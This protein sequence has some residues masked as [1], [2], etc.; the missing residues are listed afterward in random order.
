MYMPPIPPGTMITHD[1]EDTDLAWQLYSDPD[2]RDRL[3]RKMLEELE[4]AEVKYQVG[5]DGQNKKI[6]IVLDL[7]DVLGTIEIAFDM[8]VHDEANRTEEDDW[9]IIDLGD[10]DDLDDSDDL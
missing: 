7:S 2:M 1:I 4:L 5:I 3:R 9:I 6:Q 8:F 10:G